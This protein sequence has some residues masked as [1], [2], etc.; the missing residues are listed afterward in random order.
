MQVSTTM[1][2]ERFHRAT[3][4]IGADGCTSDESDPD[5]RGK[6]IVHRRKWRAYELA[7]HIELLKVNRLYIEASSDSVSKHIESSSLP[8]ERTPVCWIAPRYLEEN[9][10]PVNGTSLLWFCLSVLIGDLV[11]FQSSTV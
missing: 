7:T 2:I 4:D 8:A 6:F 10:Q 1:G 5:E 9:C 11:L 3:V